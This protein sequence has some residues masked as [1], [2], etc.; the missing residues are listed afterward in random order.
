MKEKMILIIDKP[1]TC[2]DCRLNDDNNGYPMCV[3]LHSSHGSLAFHFN[4]DKE[5]NPYCP[6]R[7]MPKEED[8]YEVGMDEEDTNAKRQW[9]KGWNACLKK[10][11][12]ETE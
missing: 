8:I 7:P 6:L 10:I 9:N 1:N 2:T 3:Y 11:T 4:G 12:G 5:R